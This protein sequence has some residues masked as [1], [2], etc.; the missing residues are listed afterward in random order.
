MDKVF[1][2]VAL[3]A[4]STITGCLLPVYAIDVPGGSISTDESKPEDPFNKET[5]SET[6]NSSDPTSASEAT[7]APDATSTSGAKEMKQVTFATPDIGKMKQGEFIDFV[8]RKSPATVVLSHVRIVSVKPFK[9]AGR[10]AEL[11]TFDVPAD[12]HQKISDGIAS[13]RLSV[14]RPGIVPKATELKEEVVLDRSDDPTPAQ[15]KAGKTALN[16]WLNCKPEARRMLAEMIVS[17]DALDDLTVTTVKKL[18]GPT[19]GYPCM[20]KA[21]MH[22]NVA[23]EGTKFVDMI[24]EIEKGKVYRA[25]ITRCWEEEVKPKTPSATPKTPATSKAPK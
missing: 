24:L 12:V 15:V 14:L 16:Q 22:Y 3:V 8:E 1:L 13:G 9:H 11:M 25:D 4:T 2:A 19:K 5:N 6:Q 23:K 20:Q 21:H 17:G 10:P 18:L 7:S